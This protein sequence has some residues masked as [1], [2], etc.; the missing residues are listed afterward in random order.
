MALIGIDWSHWFSWFVQYL[1]C[2]IWPRHNA[3]VLENQFQTMTSSNGN[4]FRITGL[5]RGE[6][7]GH[8]WIPGTNGQWRGKC[9]HFMTSCMSTD[10]DMTRPTL[11]RPWYVWFRYSTAFFFLNYSLQKSPWFTREAKYDVSFVGLNNDQCYTNLSNAP[12]HNVSFRTEMRTFL[13]WMVHHGIWNRCI[14]G[15]VN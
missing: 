2:V 12:S 1:P 11:G 7:T 3:Y 15:F 13:F 8:R 5:L 14:A 6:F 9:F 10:V 4:I